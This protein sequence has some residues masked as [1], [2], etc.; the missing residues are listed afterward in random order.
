MSIQLNQQKQITVSLWFPPKSRINAIDKRLTEYAKRWSTMPSEWDE[1]IRETSSIL[2]AAFRLKKFPSHQTQR[3][4]WIASQFRIWG[5]EN[6]TVRTAA[7]S[8]MDVLSFSIS[9]HGNAINRITAD[10]NWV[11]STTT[12]AIVNATG[13]Q[14]LR[15]MMSKEER[16]QIMETLDAIVIEDN[17]TADI[18]RART[19]DQLS[20]IRDFAN[21]QYLRTILRKL[22]FLFDAASSDVEADRSIALKSL[23][24]LAENLDVVRDDLGFLGLVD[25]IYVIEWAFAQI[26]RETLW[27]P[28]Q[29]EMMRRWPFVGQLVIRS[30]KHR[31]LLDRYIRHIAFNALR[32]I[33][34]NPNKPSL[35]VIRENGPYPFIVTVLAAMGATLN[36]RQISTSKGIGFK[37]GQDIVLLGSKKPIKL[38]YAGKHIYEDK[39]LHMV[40][41]R[42]N[43]GTVS[44]SDDYLRSAEVSSSPHV[45][46]STNNELQAWKAGYGPSPLDYISSHGKDNEVRKG[47]LL[48]C[49]RNKLDQFVEELRPFDQPISSTI[50]MRYRTNTGKDQ[51]YANSIVEYPIL[52]ACSDTSTALELIEAPP[53]HIKE[54]IVVTD[55]ARFGSAL[56]NEIEPTNEDNPYTLLIL[57]EMN[58]RQFVSKIIQTGANCLHV[59]YSD[60]EPPSP[61]P[62][63]LPK[64]RTGAL[65]VILRQS[66]LVETHRDTHTIRQPFYEELADIVGKIG[67]EIRNG[68]EE[69]EAIKFDAGQL[70]R[71]ALGMP[72]DEDHE[73]L[74]LISK[75]AAKVK[76][77]ASAMKLYSENVS[78]L[79]D[80]LSSTEGTLPSVGRFREITRVI[81]TRSD[82]TTV[83]VLCKSQRVAEE[84]ELI[85][86]GLDTYQNCEWISFN[87]LE[88][89]GAV[90]HLLVPGW[91]E[92]GAMP[93]CVDIGFASITDFILLP[94]EKAGV[95]RLTSATT[96]LSARLRRR[97]ARELNKQWNRVGSQQGEGKDLWER[98]SDIVANQ[99]LAIPEPKSIT[100]EEFDEI[101]ILEQES[102]SAVLEISIRNSEAG[103][104]ATGIPV[105]FDDLESFA[106]FPENGSVI[107]LS[108]LE[109]LNRSSS[110]ESH[111]IP[112]L[113]SSERDTN[114]AINDEG[115]IINPGG[116]SQA[117][118]LE[119]SRRVQNLTQGMLIAIPKERERDFINIQANKFLPNA[120]QIRSTANIWRKSMRRY[121]ATPGYDEKSLIEKLRASGIRRHPFTVR[122]WLV[123]DHVIAPR[124][125]KAII[126]L[127]AQSLG[128][129]FFPE[130]PADVLRAI[131]LLYDSRQRAHATL[132]ERIFSE[133]LD[134]GGDGI[135]IELDGASIEYFLRR[136]QAV[137]APIKFSRARMG[138]I[139]LRSDIVAG[140]LK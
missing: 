10:L 114:T 137:G 50:G 14:D 64:N 102:I 12:E 41:V 125:R 78:E 29:A 3:W 25:D 60:I 127:I 82:E 54:W 18:L 30:G 104:D 100:V 89:R 39:A 57:G 119:V 23:S 136:V 81:S 98:A 130:D 133:G 48:V 76:S 103:D 84:C 92:G 128:Q 9:E 132:A 32:F 21:A 20:E 24:Y 123:S 75:V 111:S 79:H 134:L 74:A 112:S 115:S 38:R 72:C 91:I 90:D 139:L 140:G 105:I 44:I 13:E 1:C 88:R 95:E 69:L 6:E 56:L 28:I 138:H 16:S 58:E 31:I 34:E 126:P 96:R 94:F 47:V 67:D 5:P 116:R 101:K 80:L 106:V 42:D 87:Q 55:G 4:I 73:Y 51:D 17:L 63:K 99:E 77:R 59:A 22:R 109:E 110:M 36:R 61:K 15:A 46:L 71:T 62:V 27:L 85:T 97:T 66:Q 122:N 33:D 120:E 107:E 70:L 52:Y 124:Q 8:A 131:D 68:N 2:R 118:S 93:K 108:E 35:L 49:R 129:I 26:R 121:I 43:N 117:G 11:V 40:Q 113:N 53:D 86:R 83:T 7:G 135:A 45:L 37:D 65:S 19:E